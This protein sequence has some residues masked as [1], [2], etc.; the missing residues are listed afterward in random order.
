MLGLRRELERVFLDALR[1]EVES[2]ADVDTAVDA[3]LVEP[4]GAACAATRSR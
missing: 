4:V 3:L 1:G 2:G